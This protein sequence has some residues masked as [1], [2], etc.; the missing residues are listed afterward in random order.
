M[1]VKY[2]ANPKTDKAGDCVIRALSLALNQ[3]WE[4]TFKDL[5]ELGL[6]MKRLPNDR[7]VFGKYLENKGWVKCSEPRNWDNTKMT[8]NQ[9]IP[10]IKE[11]IIIVKAGNLH[12]TCVKDKN[13]YDTWNCGNRTMH[14]YWRKK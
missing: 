2:N 3:S 9:A 7:K 8:I 13:I 12:V 11:D 1:F 4:T 6:K 14:T 10:F 5:C